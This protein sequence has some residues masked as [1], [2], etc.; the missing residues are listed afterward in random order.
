[1]LVLDQFKVFKFSKEKPETA[2]SNPMFVPQVALVTW[3]G[4]RAH[5]IAFYN[6]NNCVN[7]FLIIFNLLKYSAIL[8][9]NETNTSSTHKHFIS[10]NKKN[11]QND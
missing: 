8:I 11:Y 10:F 2:V 9:F 1:M 7:F 5:R 4:T 6:I 3:F